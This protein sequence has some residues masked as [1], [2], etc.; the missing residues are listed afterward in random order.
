MN[1]VCKS[2]IIYALFFT[3]FL[4][5]NA[6]SNAQNSVTANSSYTLQQCVDIAFA[7]NADVKQA[8]LLADAAKINYEQSKANIL[9]NLNAGIY[10]T[11]YNGRSINPYTNSYIDE[12]NTAASYQLTTAVTLWNGS[13]IQNY[14]KQY[15][16]SYEAGKMDAQNAKDKVTI[17]IILNYLAILSAQEQL[18]IAE[19]Q[20]DASKK[21]VEI[22]V[23][24]NND[25][26]IA[27]ADLYDMRG[28]LAA[29]ELSVIN[30]KNNLENAKLALAQL[31]NIPYSA[32]MKLEAI[33]DGM[34]PL[35]Y[36][37]TVEEVYNNAIQRLALVKAADL[38]VASTVK[39]IQA[40]KG[41][42]MPTL[43]LSGGLY[44]NY[45]SAANTQQLISS[46]DV[47]TNNYV[48]VN[49][50]KSPVYTT[51]SV[52]SSVPISYGNQWT[53]NLNSAISV[54]LQIPILNG[55]QYKNKLRLAKV[56]EQ[57]ATVQAQTTKIQLRQAIEQDY[58]NLNAAYETYKN[59]LMQVADFE[60][61]FH[62]AEIRFNAGAITIV[63]YVIAK[64]NLD[65]VQ[66]NL[67]A[68]KYNYILRTKVL[69]FYNNRNLW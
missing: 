37:A 69:D 28:Q 21:K 63:D 9:P 19:K 64:N 15:A 20:A 34:L 55:F 45:S 10:H 25:G 61:S 67:I 52:Y 49:N 23:L 24:K 66:L 44:T 39:N 41:Q 68:A 3:V 35:P 47:A 59:L 58:V 57:Q 62:S 51:Q 5:V 42:M 38:K 8:E 13:S 36:D 14:M 32:G 26:A 7:N 43:S 30:T 54:G 1:I 6:N 53:N 40:I 31:M 29:D 16:L 22:L 50:V 60:Q 65:R 2:R 46:S 48:L 17:N 18:N 4:I 27:P 12:Q 33:T 56:A 11:I